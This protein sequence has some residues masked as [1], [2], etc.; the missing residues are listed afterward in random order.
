MDTVLSKV[1]SEDANVSP[2]ISSSALPGG[3]RNSASVVHPDSAVTT[4]SQPP[5][6]HETYSSRPT[7]G[8][9]VAEHPSTSF[10]RLPASRDSCSA[11]S[12]VTIPID[13]HK[14]PDPQQP[15][16]VQNGSP[17]I[18]QQFA[19]RP[20]FVTSQSSAPVPAALPS[21][22]P[23]TKPT[24]VST[25][26]KRSSVQCKEK[27]KM[28]APISDPLPVVP[29]DVPPPIRPP[30]PPPPRSVS[31]E[32]RRP[33]RPVRPGADR[34]RSNFGDRDVFTAE[35]R[36]ECAPLI[37]VTALPLPESSQTS[38]ASHIPYRA[39]SAAPSRATDCDPYDASRAMHPKAKTTSAVSLMQYDTLGKVAKIEEMHRTSGNA[40][41]ATEMEDLQGPLVPSPSPRAPYCQVP[42][43]TSTSEEREH[44]DGLKLVC[45]V[46]DLCVNRVQCGRPLSTNDLVRRLAVTKR[47]RCRSKR[48]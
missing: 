39:H 46:A 34:Y 12:E 2:Q 11:A 26:V 41:R 31:P 35:R 43:V 20:A 33:P 25:Q 10:P 30:G 40:V 13:N 27:P 6:G 19:L 15:S 9:P 22:S 16:I 24:P 17:K 28:A 1:P 32:P 23:Q 48:S 47:A 8:A 7:S 14:A 38:W 18:Q 21:R 3:S 37:Q 29:R 45:M 5:L 4:S 44:H 42:V 36:E